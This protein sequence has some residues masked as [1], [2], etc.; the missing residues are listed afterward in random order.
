MA[1]APLSP[2]QVT[3]KVPT[4]VSRTLVAIKADLDDAV[5]E[6]VN[7]LEI[8]RSMYKSELIDVMEAISEVRYVDVSSIKV[9]GYDSDIATTV[10]Q[11]SPYTSSPYWYFDEGTTQE[12]SNSGNIIYISSGYVFRADTNDDDD[13]DNKAIDITV[14]Y[15]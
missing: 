4:T 6:Y 11:E 5:A 14:E 1:P 8:N 13:V 10:S 7:G 2:I 15:E 3:V 9:W 12:W